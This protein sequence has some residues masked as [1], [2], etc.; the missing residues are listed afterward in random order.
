MQNQKR[1][2]IESQE[3]VY[4]LMN[5]PEYFERWMYTDNI[6][7]YNSII[8]ECEKKL[9]EQAPPATAANENRFIRARSLSLSTMKRAQRELVMTQAEYELFKKHKARTAISK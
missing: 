8:E 1:Y 6:N 9:Y 7:A 4:R 5:D 2:R 3:W